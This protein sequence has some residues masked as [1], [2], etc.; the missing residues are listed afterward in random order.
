M[1]ISD[2]TLLAGMMLLSISTSGFADVEVAESL[3]ASVVLNGTDE[4]HLTASDNV[5]AKGAKVTL[6]SEGAWLFFDNVKPNDVVKNYA[7]QIIISGK[8][9]DP[10]T[11]GR[12][13]VYKQGAVVMAH[14]HDIKALHA[15]TANGRAMDFMPEYY[16][17]NNPS[18]YV[19]AELRKSLEYDNAITSISL[20]RGYMA[21][22]ACEP[23]GMGYS[24]V[25]IADDE[26]LNIG[27]PQELKGKVSFV[28]VLPWHYPSKKGW[29]GSVW[30][31]MPDG[32]KYCYQ[33]CDLTNSTWYYNWGMHPTKDPDNPDYKT[34]NQEFVPEKWGAGGDPTTMFVL[35]NAPHLLGYNEPDHT[36]QSNVSVEKAIEEWPLLMQTGRRLGSP[37][38]TDFSWLYN[39]MSQCK[40]R[41]YRV[42][43][44]VVHAYWGGKSA[45][46]WYK[47][48]KTVY[49]RTKRPIWIKEWNNGANWTKETWPSG[50]DA[51]YAKQLRDLTAIVNMLD[52]CSFIERYSI[53]NWV[54]DKRMIINGSGKL[55]PAGEFY[56]GN[57]P[58]YFFNRNNEVIPQWGVYDAP[59]LSYDSIADGKLHISWSDI[60]GEQINRYAYY[61][62]DNLITDTIHGFS[63]ALPTAEFAAN[64]ATSTLKMV[65]IPED[66]ALKGKE[67]NSLT[68]NS[69]SESK[70]A[71]IVGQA[72]AR[73][74]WQPMVSSVTN[75]EIPV[76][77]LGTPTYRNK[78]P[79]AQVV[80]QADSDHF[81]FCLRPWLYQQQPT[82]Y[83]PDTLA[84]ANMSK[85]AFQWGTINGEADYIYNVGDEWQTVEFGHPFAEQPVVIVTAHL[86]N[87]TTATAVVRNVTKNGFEVRLRYEGKLKPSAANAKV[88]YMAITPG[89]GSVNGCKAVV[90]L[91]ED[92]AVGG[93]LAGGYKLSFSEKYASSPYLFA[94]MQTEND[95]IT[96]TLRQQSR[97]SSSTILFKDREKSVAHEVVAPEQVGYL[98]IGVPETTNG[99]NTVAS[100]DEPK[101]FYNVS[102]MKLPDVP[103][104]HGL[105]IG[106]SNGIT[107]KTIIR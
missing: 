54:E 58:D 15:T 89:E 49:D 29:T 70:S 10:E 60:N 41:N 18:Q 106:K 42:D 62:D 20:K 94:Q 6:A 72:L 25:F 87:D 8:A 12:I 92:K 75:K 79:L 82:F 63:A 32:L 55:T 4:L 5:M 37:A 96:S 107:K 28:R 86:Q 53:Y 65:S 73:E 27:L 81:D 33:Q 95:T 36:E 74:N 45:A 22:L 67:S 99:I 71:V 77:I 103:S 40:K 17:S 13:S 26:D 102:G 97:T 35:P 93:I 64:G 38:T 2:K 34:Y 44:V 100:S 3:S 46:E 98:I 90:G 31:T 50:Q 52:T 69:A 57:K 1:M 80:R 68:V 101:S 83:A 84:Y 59:L 43:Y 91:T 9:F 19:S 7:S 85:G 30:K 48:L 24:R 11:N 51:Q 23:D 39:F 104:I 76:T 16:Y 47:D 66:K 56:A 78:M 88:A 14:Q 61:K 21:T 105:Y